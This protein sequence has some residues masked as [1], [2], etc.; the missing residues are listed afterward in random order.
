MEI[1]RKSGVEMKFKFAK[2]HGCGN[3]YV[4]VDC[5]E[6][7]MREPEAVSVYVSRYHFGVGSDGLI[8]VCPSDK[9]DFKMRIFNADGSE[10][11]MCGNGIRCVA[12]F[13]HD[14]GLT[15]RNPVVIETLGGLKTIR[16]DIRDGK[17][18]E[19]TVDMGEPETRPRKIPMI[20]D[21]YIFVDQ[22]LVIK[23]TTIV[24]TDKETYHEKVFF[25]GTA[26]SMGNPHFVTFV[27]DVDALD[28]EELGP[29]FEH[30]RLF[31]EGVNTEFVQVLDGNS[32]KFRVWERGSGETLACGT[33]ACAVTYACM[34]LHKA[35]KIG[36]P[37]NVYC[38][39]GLLKVT[40][41]KDNHLYLTGPAVEAFTGE[42]EIP[43]E[44]IAKIAAGLKK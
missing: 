4:Y 10:A 21:H 15:G 36:Q 16:M 31:P 26:V 40:Y 43:D 19:A 38:E 33:G 23:E 35:G 41:A 28:L 7:P 27:H 3:D 11:Q 29:Q 9:A 2:M 25:N 20:T 6:A 14:H 30:H 24:G 8:L 22:S 32:V 5:T 42:M 17:V 39:G 12:K 1:I 34:K 13:V 44:E 18:A 37:L